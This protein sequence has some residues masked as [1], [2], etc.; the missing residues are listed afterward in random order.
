MKRGSDELGAELKKVGSYLT[1]CA[2]EGVESV[3]V[4]MGGY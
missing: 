4:N 1:A 3:K 2:R